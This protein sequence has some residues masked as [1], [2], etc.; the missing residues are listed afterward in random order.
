MRAKDG[1]VTTLSTDKAQFIERLLAG[2][3]GWPAEAEEEA[4]GDVGTPTAEPPSDAQ[5]RRRAPRLARD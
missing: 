5:G 2:D 3:S 1:E 4:E